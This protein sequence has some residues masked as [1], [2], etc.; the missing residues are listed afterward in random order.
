MKISKFLALTAC[1]LFTFG[2]TFTVLSCADG[3]SSND[4]N[5]NQNGSVPTKVSVFTGTK[6]LGWSGTSQLK[7][8]A[9]AFSRATSSTEIQFTYKSNSETESYYNCKFMSGASELY[10]GRETNCS[11]DRTSTS[12]DALYAVKITNKPSSTAQ[13]FSYIP[14]ESEWAAIKT[15]GFT[16][17]GFGMCITSVDIYVEEEQNNHPPAAGDLP[18]TSLA[19]A[20]AM[21][22]GWNL[23]NTLDAHDS[24][25]VKTNKGL[26]TE[27]SW[28]M[29]A[30]TKAMIDAVAS[31]G[32][33]TIRIPVSWHNHI[34]ADNGN[35]PIDSNWM[36]RVKQIVDWAISNN[37]Y[38]ILNVHHDDLT[39]SEMNSMY[40]YCVDK[41]SEL[42][43]KSKTYLTKVWSQ[44][45]TTFAQY[46][47]R[48]VFEVLNE[49]RYRD[50][51]NNGFEAPSDLSD[52]NAIIKAYEET[53]ISTIRS[54]NGNENRFL[55]VPAYAAS[56]WNI[57]GWTIPTDS[58]TSR[59]LV[60]THAYDPY[61]FA[62]GDVDTFD[63]SVANELTYLFK[64][65]KTNFIDEGYGV[66]MGEASASDKN[67]T[68]D[69]K[70][71]I[72]DY[73]TKAKTAGIPVILWDNMVVYPNSN[74]KAE[75]HGWFNRNDCTWY[76]EELTDTMINLT[77]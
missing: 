73:F 68:D 71:W 9:S 22:I 55:M 27:T 53:C 40:G 39:R 67:N 13:T 3:S 17:I 15:N 60:S 11:I 72:T 25:A 49:P 23:G 70:K 59:L 58:A 48:L 31:K 8:E 63:D 32:F 54:V 45:A 12:A 28:G 7:I 35:Y 52:Y 24:T 5:E 16:L 20:K 62:M 4:N 30:T 14:S 65:I 43:T 1:A 46:D 69:R 75:R 50:G 33:K 61:N 19:M 42:Q 21:V 76:Y 51:V 74:N 10:A 47:N 56:P 41:D 36:S 2:T 6:D 57:A 29:P 34:T 64:Q 26:S 44:I 37:M 38:V 66:V 18:T 77:K